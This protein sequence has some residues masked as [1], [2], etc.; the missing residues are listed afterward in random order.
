VSESAGGGLALTWLS[1]RL[2]TLS[3]A[4]ASSRLIPSAIAIG[5]FW[6]SF[7]TMA[8]AVQALLRLDVEHPNASA[9]ALAVKR[10]YDSIAF[11]EVSILLQ[12][13]SS[14]LTEGIWPW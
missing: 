14:W 13:F 1:T 7:V 12:P 9:E 11:A 2:E 6:P 4:N 10:L 8:E 5:Q 3:F